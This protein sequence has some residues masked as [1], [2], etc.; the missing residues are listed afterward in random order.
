LTHCKR[1]AATN[2]SL[3]AG[4]T[5]SAQQAFQWNLLFADARWQFAG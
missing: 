2:A 1:L 3:L 4:Q 5:K